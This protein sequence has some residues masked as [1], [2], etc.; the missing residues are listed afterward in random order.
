M[1]I[2]LALVPALGKKQK[3]SV[4]RTGGFYFITPE[5]GCKDFLTSGRQP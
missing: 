4:W 2:D 3:R 1:S 5:W